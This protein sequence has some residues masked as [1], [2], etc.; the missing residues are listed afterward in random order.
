VP[1]DV[2]LDAVVRPDL[3]LL[4]K[5]RGQKA[6]VARL[7]GRAH[8]M[9]G[10]AVAGLLDA[11]F[12]A[13]AAR[14]VPILRRALPELGEADLVVRLRLVVGTVSAVL[15]AVPAPDDTGPLGTDDV[16]LQVRRLVAF[17]A[18][19]MTAPGVTEA[20]PKPRPDV[21]AP[22]PKPAKGRRRTG[23]R[24]KGRGRSSTEG[25]EV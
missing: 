14:A 21:S 11:H 16:D 2:V 3:R 10:P 4:A 15:A 13:L 23:G 25:A 20:R 8:G 22:E 5:L 7:L 17:C 24:V 9:P 19:G 12:R 1:V 18:A 6:E